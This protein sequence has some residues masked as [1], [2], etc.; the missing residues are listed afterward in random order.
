MTGCVKRCGLAAFLR[1][2]CLEGNW[3]LHSVKA[4]SASSRAQ[5]TE[6]GA[7]MYT[8][9]AA[10]FPQTCYA[11]QHASHLQV[12][13]GRE[14]KPWPARPRSWQTVPH[15]SPSTSNWQPTTT[16]YLSSCF[17]SLQS[18][19]GLWSRQQARWVAR[20]PQPSALQPLTSLC[21]RAAP[22]GRR[23]RCGMHCLT[24]ARL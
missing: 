11:L 18:M 4:A 2:T 16:K 5:S 1:Q 15:H 13:R 24:R 9:L 7:T 12:Q 10:A 19:C 23:F 21:S 3:L 17:H 14:V 22:A 20:A 8:A 6:L